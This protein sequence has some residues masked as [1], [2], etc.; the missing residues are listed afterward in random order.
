MTSCF[1][2]RIIL[3]RS[4]P[5]GTIGN[6]VSSCLDDEVDDDGAL[7]RERFLDGGLHVG[8]LVARAGP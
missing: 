4:A 7:G 3:S 8:A 2:R 5:A 6:T 1:G